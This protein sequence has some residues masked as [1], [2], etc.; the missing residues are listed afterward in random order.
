MDE[1]FSSVY[2]SFHQWIK[3]L[4]DSNKSSNGKW[5]YRALNHHVISCQ[6]W[7]EL[8]L[9]FSR[10]VFTSYLF[11]FT[12]LTLL[13]DKQMLLQ[14]HLMGGPLQAEC[15]WGKIETWWWRRVERGA[16]P[17]FF[18]SILHGASLGADN[19]SFPGAHS[20]EK[21]VP[22]AWHIWLHISKS[23]SKEDDSKMGVCGGDWA[24][25]SCSVRTRLNVGITGDTL[26]G[27]LAGQTR[28][29][30]PGHPALKSINALNWHPRNSKRTYPKES[31]FLPNSPSSWSQ[32][33]QTLLEAKGNIMMSLHLFLLC[34]IREGT[35]Q[36]DPRPTISGFQA[37]FLKCLIVVEEITKMG[38]VCSSPWVIRG[39]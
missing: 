6:D 32:M 7:S 34:V 21:N 18:I 23:L 2:N 8:V 3:P 1:V 10:A 26:S 29:M 30:Q 25:H 9:S 4:S 31:I 15:H 5:H 12:V 14:S 39:L 19:A 22:N 17:R 27:S 37:L 24:F 38:A 20:R 35:R 11:C 28:E 16:I 13:S 33:G 36:K